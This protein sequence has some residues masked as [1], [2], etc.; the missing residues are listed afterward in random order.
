MTDKTTTRKQPET[1]GLSRRDFLKVSAVV[2]GAAAFVGSLPQ[3]KRAAA[4]AEQEG[5]YPL[6][7]AETVIYSVCLN[8]HNACPI[9]GHILDGVLVKVDG[10]PY[11]AQNLQPHIAEDTPLEEAAKIDAPVC[12]KGQG[13][14]QV[15][16]DPY[17]IRKVLKR[18]GK[19]GENQ[20]ETIEWDQF[21]DEVVNGGNLF[22]EGGVDGFD[23]VWKLRDPD[24]GAKLAADSA[25]VAGGEMTVEAFQSKYDDH[26]DVLIDPDHPDLGPVNNQFVFQGGRMEHGRKELGKRFTYSSFG[27]VN[28]YLHTTI[29]EQ[30]HHIAYDM[31]TGGRKNHLKPDTENSEFVI[32]FGTSPFEA[33][34]GPTNMT[35]KITRGVA[36]RNFKYA[37]VDPRLSKTA[38]KAWKWVPAKAGTD[39]AIALGMIRWIFENDRY[40]TAFLSAPNKAA[41]NTLG[42]LSWSDATLLVRTDEMKYLA[43]ED[44]G[45]KVP[46]DANSQV[47]MLDGTPVLSVD[48]PEGELFVDTDVNGVPV[49]SVLQLLKERTFEKTP[50]EYAE[51]AGIRVHDIAE[52]A[53]EFTSHG[54]KAA[55]ELYRGPVQHTNG[56]YNGQ[57]IIALNALIGNLDWK[58]GLTKGGSHWHE[59]GSKGGAP[60][61]KSII[62]AAPGGMKKFGVHINRE[63]AHYEESTLFDG[64]PAE[65]PW[66]P[67]TN[68]LYQ[69]VIPSAAAGYPYG[70]KILFIHKGTPVLASPAGHAQIEI[71]RDPKKIPLVIACDVV[72]GET[73]MYADYII[74]DTTYMER[75]G[76]SH[77][78]PDVLTKISKV[79]QPLVAPLVETVTVDGEE[80]PANMEAF[81]ISVAKS[82]ALPGYGKDALGSGY[83][84]HSPEDYYLKMA[85]NLAFG[86]EEDG[87]EILPEATDEEIAIFQKA[88][89]HLPASVYNEEKWKKAVPPELWRSTVTLLNKGGRFEAA[90]KAYDGDK[91]NHDYSDPWFFFVEEVAQGKN[92]M[93]GENFD[94]LPKYEPIMDAAGNLM[95]PNGYDLQLITYKEVTGG[96]SRTHGAHW[97]NSVLPENFVLVN[98]ADASRLGLKSGDKVRLLSSSLPKGKFELG[99][100]R[101]YDMVGKVK[102]IEG[103]RPGTVAVSW[104]YGHWAYGSNDV[105][106][107]DKTIKGDPRRGTG[108]VPNPAMWLDPVVGDVCLT[109]PIG[110]SASFYDT[111]I[112]LE[113]V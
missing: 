111:F 56:Y 39:A 108:I 46:E 89:V 7:S 23:D 79:R 18:T 41:A 107:N 68:E 30:S 2:G 17:R 92:S 71:L 22:G 61:P 6:A 84:Y 31:A 52:L 55:V 37:V 76:F 5:Q 49:K 44:A 1:C 53:H 45:L 4:R 83:D 94:G 98:S 11:S 33:N 57:A 42:E 102:V 66:Y 8:C 69:N 113:K 80:M 103:V 16:Y 106:V 112:K 32:Y 54:K 64:Y 13:G 74:P 105:V 25:V 19:R 97:L 20:W 43:P 88:R 21:I 26:L 82:L 24:L 36:E 100:G 38:A 27:S 87:S 95:Q 48:A 77:I 63:Q 85:A 14:V 34:F 99:D 90:E 65:R 62:T 3:V 40:D 104:S 51:I 59:D 29:C 28:F 9:K 93:T 58:G 15:R 10:N 60:F 78:S 101:T 70:A 91:I 110:G 72:I 35:P 67:F 86:D 81:L 109:D 96:Q 47:V 50:D 12:S 73:S 75:W